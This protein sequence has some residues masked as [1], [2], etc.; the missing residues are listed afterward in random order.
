VTEPAPTAPNTRR[1]AFVAFA[2]VL[3][4]IAVGWG[5]Y[6]VVEKR[7]VQS[8]DDAYVAGDVIALT[9]EAA[10]T[11]NAVHA[12]DTQNVAAGDLLVEL[13]TA[14]A[15]VAVATAEAAL[16]RAARDV[17]AL[18]SQRTQLGADLHT[19]QLALERAA[20]D[21]AR[22]E[23][24]R[25]DGAVSA[26]EVAHAADA[27]AE[28]RSS[29]AAAS[30]QLGAV[31]AQI[32]G[33][34][35]ATH[36]RVLEA[37]AAL[38]GAVLAL[39]RTRVVAPVAGVIA[40]RGVQIGQR[41]APGTPLLAIVSLREAW[42]DANFKEVQLARIRIGQPA[43][44]HAD[45]YGSDVTF[46][47]RVAG[48]GAGSGS[49]FALLPAQNA[50]GNWIKIVQRLPVRIALDPAELAA[51]PLRIGL[52]T[53]VEINVADDH[54][55]PVATGVRSSPAPRITPADDEATDARIRQI[56]AAQAAGAAAG[57]PPHGP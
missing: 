45:V 36:P 19:R 25:A 20:R 39:H 17:A 54:G 43:T 26:E 22:R 44:V 1:R 38:R 5:V 23:P 7:N 42:V 49:A 56:I 34:T 15:R 57:A 9:S 16:A 8:T 52:S 11:V 27:V 51:H 41:V 29:V 55:A 53:T 46:H 47:G 48:L 14:D 28:Q 21:L 50:S 12:D 40:K 4:A 13:D 35:V 10:G 18:H 6:W 37:A 33:T 24:L 2:L 32:A 3:A 31:D 30:A